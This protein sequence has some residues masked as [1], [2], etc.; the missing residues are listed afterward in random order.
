MRALLLLIGLGGARRFASG[1]PATFLS[2]ADHLKKDA[3]YFTG[4]YAG[5]SLALS[6]L[7]TWTLTTTAEGLSA[8]ATI[9]NTTAPSTS[10][11]LIAFND[12]DAWPSPATAAGASSYMLLGTA[13]EC[14][15]A[16]RW[17]EPGGTFWA[18]SLYAGAPLSSTAKMCREGLPPLARGPQW[19]SQ[20]HGVFR[21]LIAPDIAGFQPMLRASCGDANLTHAPPILSAPN[22]FVAPREGANGTDSNTTSPLSASTPASAGDV[23]RLVWELDPSSRNLKPGTQDCNSAPQAAAIDACGLGGLRIKFS[24][25]TLFPVPAAPP[26]AAAAPA[27]LFAGTF[28]RNTVNASTSA[29]FQTK[30]WL[31]EDAPATTVRCGA[32][33]CSRYALRVGGSTAANSSGAGAVFSVLVPTASASSGGDGAPSYG[34][35]VVATAVAATVV[36]LLGLFAALHYSGA[37]RR[38]RHALCGKSARHTVVSR[39][40]RLEHRRASAATLDVPFINPLPF[41]QAEYLARL[42]RERDAERVRGEAEGRAAELEAARLARERVE[43]E[44]QRVVRFELLREALE[45]ECPR[46]ADGAWVAEVDAAGNCARVGPWRRHVYPDGEVGYAHDLHF[47]EPETIAG[48]EDLL[49]GVEN[50]W[51]PPGK[52]PEGKAAAL[53]EEAERAAE[54]ALQAEAAADEE[55]RRALGRIRDENRRRAIARTLLEAERRAAREQESEQRA[56]DEDGWAPPPLHPFAVP[57]ERMVALAGAAEAPHAGG[58]G[59]EESPLILAFQGAVVVEEEAPPARRQPTV[60][61]RLWAATRLGGRGSGG[62]GGGGSGAVTPPEEPEDGGVGG[63]DQ[64]GAAAAPAEAADGGGGG[65]SAVSAYLDAPPPPLHPSADAYVSAPLPAAPRT[66]NVW[67]SSAHHETQRRRLALAVIT[68]FVV[69]H[70]FQSRNKAIRRA[71]DLQ[72][73][74]VYNTTYEAERRKG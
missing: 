45:G 56:A 54:R 20:L 50:L 4:S 21:Q 10:T 49:A 26:P 1:D 6:E 13:G 65:G 57:A 23:V 15:G 22:A 73:K 60:L 52:P 44:R 35:G 11:T 69:R 47:Q 9:S 5:A 41:N 2:V 30:G 64:L 31:F 17:E 40:P 24:Y 43:A 59:P 55:K 67:D 29:N 8:V 37:L 62:G 68:G 19:S 58:G 28:N 27:W 71:L 74:K 14:V 48:F 3:S 34:V 72:L 18:L 61:E 42:H 53:E 38:L 7:V 66:D 51:E 63:S 33:A 32:Q 36:Y 46:G 12:T 39:A 25:R 16:T 70:C